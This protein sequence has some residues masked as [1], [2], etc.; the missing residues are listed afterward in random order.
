MGLNAEYALG[1]EEYLSVLW[2]AD[3]D[4][5][6]SAVEMAV[7]P[8]GFTPEELDWEAAEWVAGQANRSRMLLD[9]TS[10]GIGIFGVWGRVLDSPETIIRQ[11]GTVR[12]I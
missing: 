8:Q 10:V 11:H 12:V 4:L 2:S 1:G 3:V 6:V 5:T 9:T 7:I